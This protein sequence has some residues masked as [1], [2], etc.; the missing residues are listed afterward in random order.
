MPVTNRSQV[1][2][3][4]A[5]WNQ[6][7]S[8][9]PGGTGTARIGEALAR[10]FSTASDTATP[11]STNINVQNANRSRSMGVSCRTKTDEPTVS[12][13]GNADRGNDDRSRRGKPG[14]SPAVALNRTPGGSG[15][16]TEA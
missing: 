1:L 4:V 16:H 5:V 9:S 10:Y 8:W 14:T 2:V 7:I 11:I 3:L 12:L 15:P 13:P 6:A